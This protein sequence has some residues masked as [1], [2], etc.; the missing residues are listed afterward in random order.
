MEERERDRRK[1]DAGVARLS[2][3]RMNEE[4]KGEEREGT[5]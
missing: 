1:K 2:E 4:M 3:W 5:S